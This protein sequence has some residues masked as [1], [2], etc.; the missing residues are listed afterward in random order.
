MVKKGGREINV[1][2]CP[3]APK[4]VAVVELHRVFVEEPGKP[5]RQ[6]KNQV[7]EP[8]SFGE[9]RFQWNQIIFYFK[10]ILGA[11]S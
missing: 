5:E 4:F 1:I 10:Q 9:A 2:P 11:T 8:V 6:A 7:K 3:V